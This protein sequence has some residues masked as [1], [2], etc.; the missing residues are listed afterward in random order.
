M[1]TLRYVIALMIFWMV[2]AQ[3][4]SSSDEFFSRR[5]TTTFDD[6]RWEVELRTIREIER[7]PATRT[8]TAYEIL[9]DRSYHRPLPP[10]GS[11]V[12]SRPSGALPVPSGERSTSPFALP[13]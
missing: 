9:R 3:V 1:T 2:S 6:L 10:S 4:S 11:G 13:E 7:P 8:P 12:D 5:K